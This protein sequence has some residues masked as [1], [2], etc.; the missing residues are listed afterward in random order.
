[1]RFKI[2][3]E[4]F[5]KGCKKSIKEKDMWYCTIHK[6]SVCEDC[7]SSDRVDSPKNYTKCHNIYFIP[8]FNN[9]YY[10]KTNMDCIHHKIKKEDYIEDED[11]IKTE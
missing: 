2:K 11:Y 6:I 4:L 3:R 1:M 8:D 10:Y 9:K 7:F 5:C